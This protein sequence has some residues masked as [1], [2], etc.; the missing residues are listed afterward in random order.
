MRSSSLTLLLT[1][2]VLSQSVDECPSY[3]AS[4]VQSTDNSLTA[5]LTLAG[6]ACN[7]YGDDIQDLQ[8][9]VEYQTGEYFHDMQAFKSLYFIGSRLHVKIY[10]T[11]QQVYQI[12]ES[13]LA[14]PTGADTPS[15][16]PPLSFSIVEN[17]F[18]F[19][20]QRLDTNETI[21]NTSG[22]ALIFESQYI[23][24]R[25]SLLD[26]PYLYG[27]GEDSDPLRRPTSNY[28]RTLWNVGDAF[29][30]NNSNLYGAHPLYI[31]MREGQ[32]HGVF[33]A[34]SDGMDVKI[35]RSADG[36]QYLEY[37]IIGGVLDFYFMAGPTPSEVSQQ[38]AGVVGLV[39]IAAF[40]STE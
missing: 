29:L 25:T 19:S 5:T 33:L 27:L 37:D 14:P 38:Y 11:A 1:G 18:S 35:D 24:L 6:D 10:D 4:N 9:L 7:V 23:R 28:S 20:V 17:P 36:V 30:P 3:A 26:S 31:E 22:A 21:F 8:L 39:S 34:N 40:I 15:A 16:E 2:L 32:A 13:I 12:P